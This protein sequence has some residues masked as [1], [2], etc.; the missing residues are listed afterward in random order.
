MNSPA[1][2]EGEKGISVK[3]VIELLDLKPLRIEGGFFRE[4][5][6]SPEE[7]PT[8]VLSERYG[9]SGT[10]GKALGTAIYYLLT[11]ETLSTLHRLTTDE[12]YHFYLGDRITMLLLYP[13]RS[14]ET[15]TIGQEIGRGQKVQVV[16]PH[17]TW[18]GS[19]LGDGGRFALLGTTMAPGFDFS[20][21]EPGD[22]ASMI[23]KFPDRRKLIERL[24]KP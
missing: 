22:R 8:E 18:H 13:D 5:Y 20:D 23:K 19:F 6:R 4:T 17:G 21:Y 9:K 14:S 2:I 11:P 10:A 3:E 24:T 15:I 12:V 7:V 1:G 16:V